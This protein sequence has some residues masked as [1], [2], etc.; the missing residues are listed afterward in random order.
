MILKYNCDEGPAS[1]LKISLSE[2]KTPSLTCLKNEMT[3]IFF[4]GLKCGSSFMTNMY[5]SMVFIFSMTMDMT[6]WMQGWLGEQARTGEQ[7]Y[8]FRLLKSYWP[9]YLVKW[10]DTNF[11]ENWIHSHWQDWIV[12]CVHENMWIYC[13]QYYIL[14][15][16]SNGWQMVC[17]IYT[18][19]EK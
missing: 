18:A 8:Q 4:F 19:E 1:L 10:L 14:Q 16:C 11:Q 9:L 2:K 3:A 6:D 7:P 13:A 5:T 17:E 12:C 15:S